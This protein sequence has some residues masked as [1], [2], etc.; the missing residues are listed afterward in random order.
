MK[1]KRFALPFP[2]TVARLP[3]SD[4]NR[5]HSLKLEAIDQR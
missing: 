1:L 2:P 5:A 3:D 4:W